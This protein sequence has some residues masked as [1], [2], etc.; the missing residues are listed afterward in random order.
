MPSAQTTSAQPCR[1]P[2]GATIAAASIAAATLL[3]AAAASAHPFS[4]YGFGS[5]STA[6]GGAGTAPARG[7][8]VAAAAL[9]PPQPQRVGIAGPAVATRA[10]GSA[11][12]HVA[13]AF[14]SGG[15]PRAKTAP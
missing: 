2:R 10:S 14:A 12:A 6:M 8:A 3:A 13:R 1:R 7:G 15:A 4:L 5:R 9:R 11:L